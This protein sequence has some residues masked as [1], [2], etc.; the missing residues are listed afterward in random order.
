MS[1]ISINVEIVLGVLALFLNSYLGIIMFWQN[2]KSWTNKFFALLAFFIDIYIIVNFISLH[3][4]PNTPE[5]QLFWIR[6]VM[7]ICSFIGPTVFLLVYTFPKEKFFLKKKYSIILLFLF[8]T[9]SFSSITN[10]VFKSITYPNGQPIPIPGAGIP[11]FFLDFIGLFILSFII[12]IIK[13]FKSVGKDKKQIFWFLAGIII[14]FSIM[15]ITTVISVVIFKTSSA[16]FLGPLATVILMIF[17]AYAIVKYELFNIKV[18][19]TQLLVGLLSGVLISKLVFFQSYSVLIIDSI[20]FLIVLFFGYLLVGSVR[21]EVH[22][23][24]NRTHSYCPYQQ[25]LLLFVS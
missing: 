7:F 21:K 6:M 15:G 12:L 19:G 8:L 24:E 25:A 13:Y 1:V 18:I 14:T 16:V 20:T 9:S 4:I 3:P 10:L 17:I 5:A 23:K 2:K 11:F 22:Q